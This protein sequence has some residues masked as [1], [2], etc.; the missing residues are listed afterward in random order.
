ME[1][2]TTVVK[3][4]VAEIINEFW[5]AHEVIVKGKAKGWTWEKFCEE[6]GYARSTPLRWFE[7]YEL[8]YTKITPGKV[9]AKATSKPVIQTKPETK[10]RIEEIVE[11]I[12]TE[13]VYQ[14]L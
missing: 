4:K 14:Y 11:A 9:V 8:P 7:R 13:A 6:A 5:I 12:K 2:L 3:P 10:A 1:Q